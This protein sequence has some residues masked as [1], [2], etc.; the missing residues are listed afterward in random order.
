V[1]DI[2]KTMSDRTLKLMALMS[3]LFVF[4][5]IYYSL[6]MTFCTGPEKVTL[7][8][9]LGQSLTINEDLIANQ[10]T[11]SPAVIVNEK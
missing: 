3:G 6:E 9:G 7:S 8:D 5:S 4:W 2:T 1:F 10:V 11:R